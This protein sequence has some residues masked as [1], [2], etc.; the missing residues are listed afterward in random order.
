MG[1]LLASTW[2]A[3]HVFVAEHCSLL[4]AAAGAFWR[5]R[6]PCATPPAEPPGRHAGR[7]AEATRIE[8]LRTVTLPDHFSVVSRR[9]PVDAAGRCRALQTNSVVT[10]VL[11]SWNPWPNVL[12][13]DEQALASANGVNGE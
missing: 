3:L 6:R 13:V 8:P 11:A 12:S 2:L 5:Q 9:E 1:F 4:T 10:E 7:H